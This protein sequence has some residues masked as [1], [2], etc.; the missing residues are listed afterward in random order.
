MT[1]ETGSSFRFEH[2]DRPDAVI[3]ANDERIDIQ[4]GDQPMGTIRDG[5]MDGH[6]DAA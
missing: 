4:V 1:T 3:V 6:R 5:G 2:R